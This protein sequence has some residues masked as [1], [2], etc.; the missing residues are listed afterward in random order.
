MDEHRTAVDRASKQK[1]ITR[2]PQPWIPVPTARVR[3]G[4]R[5]NGVRTASGRA[6]STDA[7]RG[8]HLGKPL[9][10]RWPLNAITRGFGK[11][12]RHETVGAKR[13]VGGPTAIGWNRSESSLTWHIA[14]SETGSSRRALREA[15]SNQS[16]R[17]T[18]CTIASQPHDVR[19]RTVKRGRSSGVSC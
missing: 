3:S 18:L 13:F 12:T 4:R 14:S 15:G 11:S 10:Q 17:V 19:G 1:N 8:T 16:V 6:I 5:I 2:S 9:P 7:V